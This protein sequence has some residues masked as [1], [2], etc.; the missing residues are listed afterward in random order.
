MSTPSSESGVTDPVV[1]ARSDESRNA[2]IEAEAVAAAQ[3][4]HSLAIQIFG[5]T[6]KEAAT[7]AAAYALKRSAYRCIGC[8]R[9]FVAGDTVYLRRKR[10]FYSAAWELKAACLDCAAKW[11]PS[12]LEH[13]QEAVECEGGCGVLVTSAY[14]PM[15]RTCSQRCRENAA[16]AK[17][18]V[19][20]GDREC[21]ECGTP[22]TPTR[23]DGVYHSTACRMRAHRRRLRESA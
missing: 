15:P 12:W 18:R 6:E 16:R 14:S 19:V 11:H 5:G 17:R 13:M 10:E 7:R 3:E 23:S 8:E 9:V 4:D 22:F 2:V 20:H 21:V 1:P